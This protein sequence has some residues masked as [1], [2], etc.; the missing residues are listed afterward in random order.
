MLA[1]AGQSVS[2]PFPAQCPG[3]VIA[4]VKG[5]VVPSIKADQN[6]TVDGI[7]WRNLTPEQ[8]TR[9]DLYEG[10]F[11]CERRDVTVIAAGETRVAECYLRPASLA[12]DPEPWS[13]ANWENKHLQPALFAAE[14]LFSYD[15]FPDAA[16]LR[17]QWPM[18]E[19]RAWARYRA[20]AAPSTI[21][22]LPNASDAQLNRTAPAR[23]GF[24]CLQQ[25]DFAHKRFDGTSSGT[26]KR[27][28]FIGIDAALVLPYDPVRDRVLL[29]EQVRMGPAVRHDPNPWMLE[30]AAGMIDARE[31][32]EQAAI[33]ETMEETG[34]ELRHLEPSGNF[35]ASPGA[36]TDYFYTYVGICD[37][38]NDQSYTG[39]LADE[40]EDL[41]LHTLSFDDALALSDNGEI[42]V[43][44]LVLLL[45]WL[46]RHRERLR[47]MT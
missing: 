37:L 18:I 24:Y 47:A 1:V 44:P 10:A 39:G 46:A 15:P 45:N 23:G 2:D 9:L 29:V 21:R 42:A 25:Y 7:L 36:S 12:V 11:G 3:Y 41:R 43:A 13:L 20:V 19:K 35:Y 27:E 40:A 14:E 16:A 34:V 17:V 6:G 8:M 31:T 33:R 5:D 26:L 28:A 32:P 30:P 4:S 22:H 38:P